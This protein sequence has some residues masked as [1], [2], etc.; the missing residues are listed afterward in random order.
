MENLKNIRTLFVIS[1]SN[2]SDKNYSKALEKHL[3]DGY[4]AFHKEVGEN[5]PNEESYC[6][7]NISIQDAKDLH[8]KYGQGPFVFLTDIK[9]ELLPEACKDFIKKYNHLLENHKNKE[10]CETWL[11]EILDDKMTGKAKYFRRMFLYGKQQQ[12]TNHEEHL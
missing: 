12:I 5:N 7:Y 8:R 3:K 10:N 6:I 4:H 2:S 9:E 11:Q 1:P